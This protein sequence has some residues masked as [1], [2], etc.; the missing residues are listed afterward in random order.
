[1]L[2]AIVCIFVRVPTALR[3]R[4]A[5]PGGTLGPV[6]TVPISRPALEYQ[7]KG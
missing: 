1:M 4:A 7:G 2:G 3:S 5:P 6:V